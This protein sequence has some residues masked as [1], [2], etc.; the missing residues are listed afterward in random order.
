[1]RA[2]WPT[3]LSTYQW[4]KHGTR[5]AKAV[6]P[7]RGDDRTDI[8]ASAVAAA[9]R[10]VN[11]GGVIELPVGICPTSASLPELPW[12]YYKGQGA[13]A[14]QVRA[15]G[16]FPVFLRNG[17]HNNVINGG[18]VS[19]MTIVGYWNQNPSENTNS[20]GIQSMWP[21]RAIYRNLRFF[22]CYIGMYEI[23]SWQTV[24]D[25]LSVDGEGADK[26]NHG[27][28]Q[29]EVTEIPY[30]NNAVVAN[31]CIAQSCAGIGFRLLNPNG[32]I[33]I[34]CQAMACG[35]QGWYIGDPRVGTYPVQFAFFIGCQAD[36]TSGTGW[37]VSKGNEPLL[38][39]MH[40][41]QP[42]SGS[43]LGAH[44]FWGIGMTDC[45]ID[46]AKIHTA[47][48]CCIELDSCMNVRI[49][50][51]QGRNYNTSL[52]GFAGVNLVDSTSCSVGGD[53]DISTTHTSGGGGRSVDENGT[54]DNNKVFGNS[55]P[56][57]CQQLG[58]G[59]EF[60][61]NDGFPATKLEY[62]NTSNQSIANNTSTTITGWKS[63]F[64]LGNNFNA[65][66]GVF[67]APAAGLYMVSACLQF[68]GT[69]PASTDAVIKLAKNG[70]NVF[71]STNPMLA[72]EINPSIS[73]S[74]LFS[75]NKGD[76]ITVAVSQTSGSVMPLSS[77][78]AFNFLTIARIP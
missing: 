12:V 32:S 3:A 52:G 6:L 58:S 28:W 34:G 72:S 29:D 27:Y 75:L 7:E 2:R 44:G 67:T 35:P 54:S 55:L 57:G 8:H 15:L 31:L 48:K 76:Q 39:D 1:L 25:N 60:L 73:V 18:G 66:T 33:Y 70:S 53:S 74:G 11:T 63:S 36:T 10:L 5:Q 4:V 62:T 64:D 9:S 69:F 51:L 22:S 37:Q 65:S 56:N 46:T 30:N 42:W 14:T 59:S 20:W 21:N 38:N 40:W 49:R 71:S 50:G 23:G 19:D 61:F 41:V 26:N 77:E 78:V 24:W 45:T 68:K 17:S 16:D 13:G 47:S 43:S